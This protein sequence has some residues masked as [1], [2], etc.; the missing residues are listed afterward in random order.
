LIKAWNDKVIGDNMKRIIF[1]W[2]LILSVIATLGLFAAWAVSFSFDANRV[3][4]AFGSVQ[5]A[6]AKGEL[7]LC[8]HFANRE[9]MELVDKERLLE[10][11]VAKDQRLSF[12]GFDFRRITLTSGQSIWSVSFS[13]LIP[14]VLMALSAGF[15]GW[16]FRTSKPTASGSQHTPYDLQRQPPNDDQDLD[17]LARAA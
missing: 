9:V 2:T 1:R 12:P 6:L 8:D 17:A 7:I 5:V 16:R 3:Q 13:L 15:F 10:P 14:L 4:L 11:G